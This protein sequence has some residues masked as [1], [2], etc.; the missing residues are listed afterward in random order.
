MIVHMS[1]VILGLLSALMIVYSPNPVIGATVLAL[2]L[3]VSVPLAARNFFGVRV[4]SP[5]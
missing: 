3:G 2:V 5:A 1:L 4:I